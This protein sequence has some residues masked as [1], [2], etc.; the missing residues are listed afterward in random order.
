[1]A[2]PYYLKRDK[3]RPIE[4]LRQANELGPAFTSP[5]EIK[6]YVANQASE[7]VL[8]ELERAER[9]RKND[10]M[11]I[12]SKGMAYA[13]KGKKTEALRIIKELEEMS[14]DDLT[15]AHFI[16]Q[17]YAALNEKEMTL[18]WL[19][20]GLTARAIGMFYKDDPVFDSVRH[21]PRF[22]DLLRRM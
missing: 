17:I 21:D 10:P 7:E 1:E 18:S 13:M 12:F 22:A 14:G 11:L 6:V 4:L 9:E 19:E 3:E 15:E 20:R 5:W 8:A 2:L 16:A